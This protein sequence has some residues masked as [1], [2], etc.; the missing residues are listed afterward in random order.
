[1]TIPK[2]EAALNIAFDCKTDIARAASGSLNVAQI[3]C[4][5]IAAH[6]GIEI[7][8]SSR[9]TIA[10]QLEA[11]ISQVTNELAL[12]FSDL[13]QCFASLGGTADT[14]CIEIL[15]ELAASQDGFV[16]L[17]HMKALR[18]ELARG[19]ERLCEKGYIVELKGKFP[20][21]E[22]HVFCDE[23][24]CA[25]A[26]DDPQ[27]MFYLRH[28][29]IEGLARSTGKAPASH[30]TKV[31]ISYSHADEKWF[32]QL[33]THLKPLERNYELDVWDDTRIQVGSFWRREIQN[34]IDSM[35]VGILLVSANYLASD[36]IAQNELPP[37]LAAAKSQGVAV[38]PVI[39]SECL[40]DD[41]GLEEFQSVNSLQKPLAA[42]RKSQ[43]EAVFA[44]LARA[45]RTTLA[46]SS[47]ES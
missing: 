43:Q 1:M 19:I 14:T 40:F 31:F 39:V 6:E 4:A 24:A 22:N 46:R 28:I 25:I 44:N 35:R 26:I 45:L 15:K 10:S 11:R 5:H 42:L 34:A 3:L 36:F 20:A 17:N 33:R 12:K 29:S 2:G 38:M 16:S 9:R 27:L 30:R 18:S 21:Y 8:Q 23:Q 32:E 7:T 47:S 37:M 41:S 13:V